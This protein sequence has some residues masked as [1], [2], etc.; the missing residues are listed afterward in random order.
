MTQQKAFHYCDAIYWP[1]FWK[2]FK[3]NLIVDLVLLRPGVMATPMIMCPE[4]YQALLVSS[5]H[6][7]LTD[8]DFPTEAKNEMIDIYHECYY[9]WSAQQWLKSRIVT[10]QSNSN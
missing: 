10:F 9:H 8:V 3:H 4:S 7:T 5:F 1:L 2:N 6:N